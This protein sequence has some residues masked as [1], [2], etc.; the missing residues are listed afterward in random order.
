MKEQ[1][2][3]RWSVRLNLQKSLRTDASGGNVD[4]SSSTVQGETPVLRLLS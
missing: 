2:E 4:K 1:P 3:G